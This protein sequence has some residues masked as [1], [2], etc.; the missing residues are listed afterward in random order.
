VLGVTPSAPGFAEAT[1]RPFVGELSWA[2]GTVPTPHGKIE[3]S[4][5][6]KGGK[7]TLAVRCPRGV[8][9]TVMLGSR[10]YRFSDGKRHA[11]GPI[12][13]VRSV[14]RG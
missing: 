8:K 13:P 3:V 1:I 10:S 7:T 14:S 2:K 11:I 5:N 9:A 12:W 4:W 6:R